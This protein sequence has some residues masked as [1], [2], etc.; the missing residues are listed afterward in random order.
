MK[1]IWV[2]VEPTPDGQS[3]MISRELL[4]KAR[5][6]AQTVDGFTWGTSSTLAA[7]VG[8]FGAARLLT[9]G[10]IGSALPAPAVAAAVAE[11]IRREED[12]DAILIPHTYD[13]RDI[14]ARLSVRLDRPVLTN[15]LDLS[16]HDQGLETTQA[17]FGGSSMV[18]ARFTT[19]APGIFVVRAKSFV[20][21]P[22]DTFAPAELLTAIVPDLGETNAATVTQR[23]VENRSGISL[24]DASVV[25]AG[26]RGLG[27]AAN[28]ALIE[29]LAELL[30]GAPAA[31]RA[32]VDAGWVPYSFQVGQTGR[33]VKPDLYIAVGISGALQHLVG[34]KGAKR[35]IAI[36]SDENAPIVAL[37]D[38]AIIG[39][40]KQILPKLIAA[41]Q[42][43]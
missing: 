31:S 40:A 29:R 36:N 33:V 20:A 42:A 7:E 21:E 34:M 24:D 17:L 43:P 23:H 13:G 25:V 37:S 15:V 14:A 26:G 30:R 22:L 9:I 3:S 10:D 35:I 27:E 19:P 5:S 1:H 18:R 8:S 32:I 2:I 11:T 28:Y 41:L 4:S 12:V 16:E 6:L 38:L 39:D